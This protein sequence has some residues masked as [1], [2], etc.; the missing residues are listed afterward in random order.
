MK[1]HETK[2]GRKGQASHQAKQHV[3]FDSTW[4]AVCFNCVDQDEEH[5]WIQDVRKAAFSAEC[6]NATIMFSES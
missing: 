1:T 4:V 2:D 6:T 3:K 5:V